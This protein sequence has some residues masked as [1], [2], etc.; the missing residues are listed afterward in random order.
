AI[1]L[2]KGLLKDSSTTE[3]IIGQ[4]LQSSSENIIDYVPDEKEILEIFA[5]KF[6]DFAGKNLDLVVSGQ[7]VII[8]VEYQ[9]Y[10]DEEISIAIGFY[11][12]YDNSLILYN[13]R[14]KNIF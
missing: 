8:E 12:F 4:Y 14:F 9:N 7:Y 10:T 11:D 2:E 5:I 1:L 3:S 13:S 6:T